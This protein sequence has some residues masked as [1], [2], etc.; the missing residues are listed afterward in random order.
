MAGVCVQRGE[1]QEQVSLGSGG[2]INLLGTNGTGILHQI[3]ITSASAATVAVYDFPTT[4]STRQVYGKVGVNTGDIFDL[5][6]PLELNC[7]IVVIGAVD[8]IVTL[9]RDT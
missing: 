4:L 3:A 1:E 2:S 7:R 5:E 8:M 6:I 9:S